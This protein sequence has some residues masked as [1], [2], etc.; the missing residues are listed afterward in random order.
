MGI[1][2]ILCAVD[3]GPCMTDKIISKICTTGYRKHTH[4]ELI[5]GEIIKMK[6]FSEYKRKLKLDSEILFECKNAIKKIDNSADVVLYGSRARG[7][8]K[9]ESD[10]DLLIITDGEATLEREDILRRQLFPIELETGYVLTVFLISRK[11]WDSPLYAAMP[12][13]QNIKEDGILL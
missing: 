8:A 1:M 12:L 6:R 5:D 4:L 13:Y 7:D 3:I 9:P 10:Y 11:D 2:H